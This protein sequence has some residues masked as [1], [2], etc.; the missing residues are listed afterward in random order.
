M[1]GLLASVNPDSQYPVP[2]PNITLTPEQK[3]YYQNPNSPYGSQAVHNQ[4]MINYY[5]PKAS[6]FTG[7]VPT[8][9]QLKVYNSSPHPYTNVEHTPSTQEIDNY[10]KRYSVP[11]APPVDMNQM[12]K[13]YGQSYVPSQQEM[14]NYYRNVYYRTPGPVPSYSN[15]PA[16]HLGQ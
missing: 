13:F 1:G 6:Q 11:G 9:E 15:Y 3:A 14:N 2:P 4:Q 5:G 7:Y 10:S 16:L 8:Q 12:H